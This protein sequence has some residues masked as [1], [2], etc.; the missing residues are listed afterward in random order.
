MPHSKRYLQV[1]RVTFR[2]FPLLR[3][4]DLADGKR[5]HRGDVVV[6]CCRC[7]GVSKR[8]NWIASQ[9]CCPLCGAPDSASFRGLH[10]FGRG[11]KP[12]V[13]FSRPKLGRN[14][15]VALG[16][17]ILTVALVALSV[18]LSQNRGVGF[19]PTRDGHYQYRG[20]GG[21]RYT[22]GYYTI[23]GTVYRFSDGVLMGPCTFAMNER[24]H[25]LKEDGTLRTDWW[26][27]DGRYVFSNEH[28]VVQ[29][30]VPAGGKAGFYDLE[31]LGNV[32]VTEKGTPGDGWLLHEGRLF[33]LR[34]G[35]GAAE[36]TMPGTFD[37]QGRYTP[38]RAGIV[39]LPIGTVY[40]QADGSAAD[41]SVLSQGEIYY[42]E[43]G[44][45]Q[46]QPPEGMEHITC[47]PTGAW[48]PQSDTR[49]DC[50]G[51]S[52]IL[53]GQTGLVRTGWILYQGSAYL[54]DEEGWL[55]CGRT[56]QE[57]AGT[58]DAMGRF[59][60]QQEGQ[61]LLGQ[62][63]CYLRQDG[64]LLTGAVRVED[65]LYLYDETGVLRVNQSIDP[66]GM[67]DAG[68]ALRPYVSGM[69]QVDGRVYCFS[70]TGRLLT[71]WQR[72]GKMYCFDS[73]TGERLSAAV[74][75][76]RT[77]ALAEDG[78]FQPGAE[79]IY[80]LDG[81]EYYLLADGT[82]V[83][84][85]RMVGDALTYFD[86]ATGRRE[87]AET[88]EKQGW[89][90]REGG[91][92]Y[93]LPT[94]QAA[95]GW[96][97]VEGYVY[98]FDPQ[99]GAAVVG[100]RQIGGAAYTFGE[101]GRLLPE[102]PLR[103]VLDGEWTRVG[104]SGKLE[105]GFLCS[106]NHLY[107]YDLKTAHLCN[108]LPA[109]VRGS[110]SALGGYVLP[111]APGVFAADENR[112]YLDAS[113]TV[114]TG[115][116]LQEG[117]LYY[118]DERTGALASDGPAPEGKGRF[119]EGV[120]HP[121]KDGVV[122]IAGRSYFFVEDRLATGWVRWRNGA[123]YVDPQ[124]YRLLAATR[125]EIQGAVR[126]FDDSGVY[127][128]SENTLL[129]IQGQRTLILEDGSLPSRDGLYAA[130]GGLYAVR[131]GGALA[132]SPQEIGLDGMQVTLREGR[133]FPVVPGQVA[134][135]ED[136][137]CLTAEG[138]LRTGVVLDNRRL[139]LY[140]RK[141]GRLMR[142]HL[143]FGSDGAYH[144]LQ[145]GLQYV[146]NPYWIADLE[147]HVGLGMIEAPT[148]EAVTGSDEIWETRSLVDSEANAAKG[149][150]LFA[151]P[152][153][154]ILRT[155]FVEYQ[156]DLYYFKEDTYCMAKAEWISGLKLNG[157]EW[158][159]YA[160]EDGKIALGWQEIDGALHY[161]DREKGMLSDV[162][163]D[164]KYINPYGEAE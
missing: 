63:A 5:F 163:Q 159:Y 137:Y 76:G 46:F 26:I 161:F 104:V 61:Q 33:Y 124:T 15:A 145:L 39:P 97:A 119:Q 92:F 25:I 156:G 59:L 162:V 36:E 52:V 35:K 16:A 103:I 69:H 112:Y 2:D 37:A 78:A 142:N 118:A 160:G 152:E 143:G 128:P 136:V 149:L 84:G 32:Y 105:G 98:Y 12:P 157:K 120:F 45:L 14:D 66:L 13:Y 42:F 21:Q 3:R 127:Q 64:S 1:R 85:W 134:L 40:L 51:G 44:F 130:G 67:T 41:G 132:K 108:T 18:G 73:R 74:V 34:Q 106:E 49:V 54:A 153:T 6:G 102:A 17:F 82:V 115:W 28:G 10:A 79:G 22:D 133:V 125:A 47:A 131:E 150:T 88:Q 116:F 19:S 110:I 93:T 4:I 91:R 140:N 148:W 20:E 48:I 38:P 24:V 29:N 86:E 65:A 135:G 139:Y 123:G 8:E 122:S 90:N 129:E 50:Q 113:G 151:D 87:A 43:N 144:P 72:C 77:Y 70:D 23:D 141:D 81:Q 68:G 146:D 53:A 96:T 55:T 107:F 7:R 95:R 126:R 31:G 164:G 80:L 155:G 75:N 9:Q 121:A 99:S 158:I 11:G 147:G 114:R 27:L 117:Q 94:G 154:G 100:T 58:F 138:G 71:G 30:R 62:T 56:S 57:P 83:T 111:H 101:D 60:P 109:G 89:A